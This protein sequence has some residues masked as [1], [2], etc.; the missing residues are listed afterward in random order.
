MMPAAGSPGNNTA[1]FVPS[2]TGCGGSNCSAYHGSASTQVTVSRSQFFD[3][4]QVVVNFCDGVS[5]LDSWVE[6]C[7]QPTCSKGKALFE[8]HDTLL[9]ER[10]LG[11]PSPRSGNDQRWIDNING[12]VVAR[13]SRFGGEGGGF[14]VVLNKAS[15]L[16]VPCESSEAVPVTCPK[17]PQRGPLPAGT[18]YGGDPQSSAVI[19]DSCQI[20][21]DGNHER[22]ANIYLEQIPAILS[23]Q[24][25]QGFA[26]AWWWGPTTNFS[27]IKV[28][29][30]LDLNGPQLD[31]AAEH[32]RLLRYDIGPVNSWGPPGHFWQ[33]PQQ[34][35]PYVQ[36]PVFNYQTSKDSWGTDTPSLEP[37][38]TGVWRSNQVVLTPLNATNS[39]AA[40]R[41]WRCVEGGKPG[42]WHP[43]D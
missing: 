25:C 6:G 28:D 38:S 40:P 29:P 4:E 2:G 5:L 42:K 9:I 39:S 33:L 26:Y 10:M 41:G 37:P 15:F 16:Q 43:F 34:L 27:F 20:D 7:Y 21:S 32:P 19:L 1:G 3:N 22:L 30:R 14:T 23:V 17:P 31:Y 11:V 13:N 18:K 12:M 8:N 24:N 35:W 36:N